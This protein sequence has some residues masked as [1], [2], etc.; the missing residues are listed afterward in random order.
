MNINVDRAKIEEIGTMLNGIK[1]SVPQV[2]SRSINKTLVNV[3]TDAVK[4]IGTK[5][6]LKA[7]RI[8]SDFRQIKATVKVIKGSVIAKGNP[9][10]LASF[11]GTKELKSG[12]VSVKYRL[13]KDFILKSSN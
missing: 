5:I 2:L 10:G 11:L 13:S 8:R 3:R 4:R 1:G 12:G 7:A 9:V 6:N